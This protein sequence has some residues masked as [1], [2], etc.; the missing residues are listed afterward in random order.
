MAGNGWS[1]AIVLLVLTVGGVGCS[2]VPYTNRSQF[3]IMSES[4]DLKLG[5]DAYQQVLKESKIVKDPAITAPVL[6]IGRRIA[7]AADKPD[8]KWEFTVIDDPKQANAFCLPG[9]KVAVYTG[10]FPIAQT[11]AGLAAVIGHEVAHAL[12]RHGAERM[13]TATALQVGGA[14]VAVAAGTQGAGAQQAAMAAYGLGTQVGVAL[15]FSRSQESEA[16]HIG[17]IMMAKAG[18]DPEAAIG[19]W[20]RMEKDEHGGRPPEWL[21]THPNPA[22]RQQDIRGWIAEAMKYYQSPVAS[23]ND[24]LPSISGAVASSAGSTKAPA[25]EPKLR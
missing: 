22:T 14:A 25:N 17:L 4:Q 10:I 12:A 7:A 1:R 13:S 11:D 16:D 24:P 6:E 23:Q 21:S 18:Y 3:M 9:G 2:T 19:L 8:Y 15:P 20:Q 5:A